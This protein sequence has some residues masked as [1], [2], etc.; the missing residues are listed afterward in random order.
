MATEPS[1]RIG[2]NWTLV[3]HDA[4]TVEFRTGVWNTRTLTVRD[5]TKSGTLW[6]I[7]Q[8]ARQGLG[9]KEIAAQTGVRTGQVNGLLDHL[10]GLGVVSDG[11]ASVLDTYLLDVVSL[12]KELTPA[13]SRIVVV[14]DAIARHAA[15]VLG[16]ALPKHEVELQDG[17]FLHNDGDSTIW[18]DGLALE[19]AAEHYRS[20]ADAV[21]IV[22][23]SANDPSRFR[24]VDTLAG[25]IGFRW[26]HATIDGPFLFVG[27]TVVPGQSASYADFEARVAMNLRERE[28]YLKYKSAVAAGRV[29]TAQADVIPP[30]SG[31]VGSHVA[32]EALNLVTCGTNSTLNKVLAI[33]VPTMEIA[34]HEVLPLPGNGPYANRDAVALY[35]DFREWTKDPRLA[36]S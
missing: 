18:E 17:D 13:T 2:D 30:L 9:C 5:S 23:T 15:S 16:E 8:L 32:L 33:Y 36:G 35:F 21:V 7:V 4:D 34:Y 22:A 19:T 14:G 25:H 11:P 12:G 1:R 26:I 29:I 27:P 28:S 20:L 31:I 24:Y 10:T 3:A 6:R